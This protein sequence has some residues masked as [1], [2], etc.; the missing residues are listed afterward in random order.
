MGFREKA[1]MGQINQPEAEGDASDIGKVLEQL[2]ERRR[3]ILGWSDIT[4][5]DRKIIEELDVKIEALGMRL[6]VAANGS[7]EQGDLDQRIQAAENWDGLYRAIREN[8]NGGIQG[9]QES[10]TAERLIKII[11]GVR[12]GTNILADV[13]RSHGIRE[14]VKQLLSVDKTQ[15]V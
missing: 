4:P 15:P 6:P 1:E 2:R 13:T 10:F 14:K 12:G 3:V 8:G 7:E 11:A 9:S 5:E